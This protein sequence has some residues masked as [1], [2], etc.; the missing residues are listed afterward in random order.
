MKGRVVRMETAAPS[1]SFQHVRAPQLIHTELFLT[2]C[3]QLEKGDSS[4][5]HQ[6]VQADRLSVCPACLRL[7]PQ[8]RSFH[9][10]NV[11]LLI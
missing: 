11:V 9:P 4:V 2:N 10:S 3:V 6:S 5:V 8:Q 7:Q 1:S